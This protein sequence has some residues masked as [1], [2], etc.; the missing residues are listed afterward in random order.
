MGEGQAPR[1]MSRPRL[2][3]AGLELQKGDP[4]EQGEEKEEVSYLAWRFPLSL[5]KRIHQGF[6]A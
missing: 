1:D 6:L 3:P 2:S 4:P 5:A